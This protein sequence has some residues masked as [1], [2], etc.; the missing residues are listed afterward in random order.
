M[1]FRVDLKQLWC[2]QF[3]SSVTR[4]CVFVGDRN[5]TAV[6]AASSL[7]SCALL[8]LLA[9]SLARDME[10][11]RR[12]RSE[13]CHMVPETR[14]EPDDERVTL[15]R[16][17]FE[18]HGRVRGQRACTNERRRWTGRGLREVARR[19]AVLRSTARDGL[20]TRGRVSRP[21]RQPMMYV[22]SKSRRL[23]RGTCAG[24]SNISFYCRDNHPRWLLSVKAP[25]HGH[26]LIDVHDILPGPHLDIDIKGG[27]PRSSGGGGGGRGRPG[28]D[29]ICGD[30]KAHE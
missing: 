15:N 29:P 14:S 27:Q 3:G 28:T 7:M 2:R 23:S 6:G 21:V 17:G 5:T 12:E 11:H 1:R 4:R 8:L 18:L 25:T 30:E 20:D 24:Q 26:G 22:R 13:S 10:R 19:K 9:A 16:V